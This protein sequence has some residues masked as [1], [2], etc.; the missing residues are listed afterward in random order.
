MTLH[1]PAMPSWTH[2]FISRLAGQRP[3]TPNSRLPNSRIPDPAG[4]VLPP[5]W[6][7]CGGHVS[8]PEPP[9]KERREGPEAGFRPRNQTA[10]QED[11]NTHDAMTQPFQ[12]PTRPPTMDT[13]STSTPLRPLYDVLENRE[14]DVRSTLCLSTLH[15]D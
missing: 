13:T 9:K 5:K 7:K 2:C 11:G 4:A 10:K 6:P 14:S 8:G 15:I 3:R 12:P 1:R